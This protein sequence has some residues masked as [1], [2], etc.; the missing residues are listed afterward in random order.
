[1]LQVALAQLGM[2]LS[3]GGAA[4]GSSPSP[5]GGA[6]GWRAARSPLAPQP[7]SAP[8]ASASPAEA[9][10]AAPTARHPRSAE[11]PARRGSGGTGGGAGAM[12]PG[13]G[14]LSGFTVYSNG[15]AGSP[16]G[17]TPCATPAAARWRDV[18]AAASGSPPGGS[19]GSAPP[20]TPVD[21]AAHAQRL[22]SLIIP[23]LDAEQLESLVRIGASMATPPLARMCAAVAELEQAAEPKAATAAAA[24]EAPA[25]EA[26]DAGAAAAEAPAFS[27]QS[28]LVHTVLA[29]SHSQRFFSPFAAGASTVPAA[30]AAAPA[31]AA[32]REVRSAPS[33]PRAAVRAAR[34]AAS[35]PRAG[36][37]L[38]ARGPRAAAAAPPPRKSFFAPLAAAQLPGGAGGGLI[39]AVGR[40]PQPAAETVAAGKP[41]RLAV[42]LPAARPES[43]AD[44]RR[45]RAA[46]RL[47]AKAGERL[48]AEHRDGGWLGAALGALSPGSAKKRALRRA[49]AAADAARQAAA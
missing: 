24:A 33:S 4:G 34:P 27:P 1:M 13:D 3:P 2:A 18:A 7:P 21:P 20:A 37:S 15:L 49:A 14:S 16:A 28:R 47:L 19:G 17:A 42:A 48:P 43:E 6:A 45:R 39:K 46:E 12:S 5:L 35:P 8:P 26:P 11:T 40:A 32:P 30:A 9:R 25:A 22:A 31:A 29:D 44:A 41:P 36:G 38:S 23:H 10:G